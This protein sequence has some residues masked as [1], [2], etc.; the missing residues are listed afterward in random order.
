MRRVLAIFSWIA[1]LAV[2]VFVAVLLA[3]FL[4]QDSCLDAGGTYHAATGRCEVAQ[5]SEYVAQ[6]ARPGRFFL[7]AIFLVL[8]FIPGWLVWRLMRRLLNQ[9]VRPSP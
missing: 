7:W 1:P 8:I 5:G 4:E 9:G 6:F 3:G 2:S